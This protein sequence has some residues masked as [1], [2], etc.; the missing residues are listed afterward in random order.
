MR[1]NRFTYLCDNED[2]QL[3]KAVAQRLGVSESDVVRW[4]VRQ[5]ARELGVMPSTRASD[6]QGEWDAKPAP[7]H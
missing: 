6:N 2:Q 5:A 3:R 4:S 1:D 7:A